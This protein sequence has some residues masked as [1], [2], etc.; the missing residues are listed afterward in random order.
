M[1]LN[2]CCSL[3]IFNVE[4]S[5]GGHVKKTRHGCRID[6]PKKLLKHTIVAVMQVNT[7]KIKTHVL[8]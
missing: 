8:L 3:N 6:F 7:I 4:K 2:W 1:L 5:V